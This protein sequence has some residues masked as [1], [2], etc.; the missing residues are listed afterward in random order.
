MQTF[1]IPK[2]YHLT[3]CGLS[4]IHLLDGY[5]LNTIKKQPTVHI[6]NKENLY[7]LLVDHVMTK[8][9]RL[10]GEEWTFLLEH[11]HLPDLD[12]CESF[13]IKPSEL[14]KWKAAKSQVLM[15]LTTEITL[16]MLINEM[17]GCWK[18]VSVLVQELRTNMHKPYLPP[19]I[20]FLR[21]T[22]VAE[23]E[24]ARGL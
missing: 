21:K 20:L 13:N 18:L 5:T 10:N 4:Y 8:P 12:V 15:P 14:K 3:Q 6:R 1:D 19:D 24:I 7:K 9:E 17:F 11:A 16:R 22:E 23:W 2:S